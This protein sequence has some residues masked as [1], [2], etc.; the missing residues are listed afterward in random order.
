MADGNTP[1]YASLTPANPTIINGFAGVDLQ[2]AQQLTSQQTMMNDADQALVGS[3]GMVNTVGVGTIASGMQTVQTVA[4]APT[5]TNVISSPVTQHQSTPETTPTPEAPPDSIP[6]DRNTLIAVLQFLK[7]NNLKGTED[8]LRQESHF[9]EEVDDSKPG[10]GGDAEVSSV[11]SAFKSEGDPAEYEEAYMSLHSFIEKSLDAYKHE[12]SLVLYPVFVHMYLELVY[13]GHEEVSKAFLQKLGPLQE[14]YYQDDIHKLSLVTNRDHMTG[15]QI[16]DNFRS[17]QFTVR[18]SRDSFSHLKRYLTERGGSP[19]SRIINDRLYLYVYE[20]VPRTRSQV[21][22]TAGAQ[23]GEAPKQVNKSRVFYGLLKEPELPNLAM[24][25]E[26][27]E[28]EGDKPKKKKPK[29][30]SL[31]KSKKNDP[32]AP[33]SNRIPLPE[34]RDIDKLEKAKAFRDQQKRVCLNKDTLPS[35]CF[36]TF[37]NA[38]GNITAIDISDDSSLLAYASGDSE[39]RVQSI[40]PSKLRGMKPAEQLNDIDKDAGKILIFFILYRINHLCVQNLLCLIDIGLVFESQVENFN[41]FHGE[42]FKRLCQR[43]SNLL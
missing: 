11:L 21:L 6:V 14:D 34:L 29:K 8:L 7:K 36:Y 31:Q 1:T 28:E 16:M 39:V 25:E 41:Y 9:F 2:T 4:T 33:Q 43:I 42:I 40:T 18:M 17:S 19:V 5:M 38:S 12:R 10:L 30:D 13:N 24:E 22:A 20:G 3:M 23:E 27:G 26:E 32:N 15:Y 35:I 37:L